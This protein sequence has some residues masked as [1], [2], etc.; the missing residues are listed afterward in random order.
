VFLI[1]IDSRSEKIPLVLIVGIF[2]GGREESRVWQ[3]IKKPAALLIKRAL[4]TSGYFLH[5]FQTSWIKIAFLARLGSIC[6]RICF[7]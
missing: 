3:M 7:P 5:F 4:G 2:Y 6:D 1:K